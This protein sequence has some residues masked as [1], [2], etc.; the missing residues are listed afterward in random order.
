MLVIRVCLRLEGAKTRKVSPPASIMTAIKSMTGDIYRAVLTA[1]GS[2]NFNEYE[3]NLIS[4][5]ATKIMVP[6]KV[7]PCLN[8]LDISIAVPTASKS[9][10][11]R[12]SAPLA[13]FDVPQTR[14]MF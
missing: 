7:Y 11:F 6:F 5:L 13:Q 1:L 14:S 10:R 2:D 3:S 12:T 8:P 9:P 4:S